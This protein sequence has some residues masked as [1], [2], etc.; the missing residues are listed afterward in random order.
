MSMNVKPT[1]M[2]VMPMQFVITRRALTH[3][4]ARMA[5]LEMDLIAVVNVII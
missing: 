4:N 5:S 1:L 2:I 3:V